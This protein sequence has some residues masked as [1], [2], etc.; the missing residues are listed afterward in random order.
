MAT[1]R[2]YYYPEPTSTLFTIDLNPSTGEYP[3][4]FQ[5]TQ[6]AETVTSIRGDG[7]SY[8]TFLGGMMSVRVVCDAWCTT[9][10]VRLL[11]Q[12]ENHVKRGGL[13]GLT[14]D[15]DKAWGSSII[16]PG[17]T[18]SVCNTQQ[19]YEPT[20]S[21]S[22]TDEIVFEEGSPRYRI[23]YVTSGQTIT[24]STTT[25]THGALA[26][27]FTTGA[28]VHARWRDFFPLLRLKPGAYGQTIIISESDQY[29]KLDIECLYELTSAIDVAKNGGVLQVGE[30]IGQGESVGV[31]VGQIERG[32]NN[33]FG[34][35]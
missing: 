11:R 13:F 35:D 3:A 14:L 29:F 17:T 27:D 19:W 22:N 16:L 26:Y 23:D 6:E 15:K 18:T 33:P 24:N 4:E 30:S 7:K 12:W 31:L 8:V 20:T 34:S 21:L 2:I 1:G 10:Q 25:F 5:R 32:T 28:S 9:E